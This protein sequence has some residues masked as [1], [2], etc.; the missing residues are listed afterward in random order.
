M[1][2]AVVSIDVQASRSRFSNECLNNNTQKGKGGDDVE[3]DSLLSIA[4]PGT[5]ILNRSHT[6]SQLK[7]CVILLCHPF[8]HCGVG[9][10]TVP[11]TKRKKI[12]KI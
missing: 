9:Q 6:S 4:D 1:C 12:Q 2:P 5:G 10:V 8:I 7:Y 3:L 11:W